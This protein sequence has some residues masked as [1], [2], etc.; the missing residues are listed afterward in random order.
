VS[1]PSPRAVPGKSLSL[2]HITPTDAINRS[3]F[4]QLKPDYINRTGG[5]GIQFID[6]IGLPA[7]E[8]QNALRELPADT[9]V[10]F[11]NYY[12]DTEGTVY[13][14]QEG[15]SLVKESCAC[16]VYSMWED[17]IEAGVLGGVVTSGGRTAECPS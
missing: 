3:R 1:V 11:F 10:V 6:L 5:K 15:I 8:L 2:I 14:L 12:R 9:V 4:D 17:K 16:P 13:T 7:P